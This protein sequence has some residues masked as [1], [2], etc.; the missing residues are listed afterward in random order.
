LS[1]IEEWRATLPESKRQKLINHLSVVR[2]WLQATHPKDKCADDP[3]KA[4]AVA[5]NRFKDLTEALP[6]AEAGPLW[7]S[8]TAEARLHRGGVF[9]WRCD[10]AEHGPQI[11]SRARGEFSVPAPRE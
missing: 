3:V 2:A 7:E 9:L 10:C 4:A 6:P 5:W 8:V 1:A 11:G